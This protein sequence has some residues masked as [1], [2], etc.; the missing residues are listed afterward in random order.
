MKTYKK[1][2]FFFVELPED[3][4]EEY[5]EEL[6]KILK[7][8]VNLNK[9]NIVIDLKNTSYLSSFTLRILIKYHKI[10]QNAG[11]SFSFLH[12]DDELKKFLETAHLNS[13]FKMFSSE[14]DLFKNAD[15]LT[16]TG[17]EPDADEGFSFTIKERDGITIIN[18][19]GLLEDVVDMKKFEEAVVNRL[20]LKQYFFIFNLQH[21]G[22]IDSL[23]IGRFV[24]LNRF[25]ITRNG[26]LV[27]CNASEMVRDFFNVLG[28]DN[29]LQIFPTEDEAMKI[30]GK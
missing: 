27:F 16:G 10:Y 21:L 8:T 29:I 17:S 1:G 18:F 2:N 15:G 22:F 26:K 19:S 9:Y 24:K 20:K 7:N 6:E 25:L 3:L 14:D 13:I 5:D 12:L 30:L 23:C 11:R 4:L 28:L